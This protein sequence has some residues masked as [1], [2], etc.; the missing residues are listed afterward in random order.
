VQSLFCVEI[1]DDEKDQKEVGHMVEDFFPVPGEILHS[2]GIDRLDR[3][4]HENDREEKKIG[5]P[6]DDLSQKQ[7]LQENQKPEDKENSE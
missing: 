2:N 1:G 7:I 3:A 4:N 5:L 6:E